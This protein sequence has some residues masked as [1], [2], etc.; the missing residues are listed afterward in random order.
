ME[1][2][3]AHYGFGRMAFGRDLASG[4]LRR[5]SSSL[6]AGL[7]VVCRFVGCWLSSAVASS[8]RAGR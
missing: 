7:A 6:Y 4:M 5:H 8:A 3:Q 2:P 1:E